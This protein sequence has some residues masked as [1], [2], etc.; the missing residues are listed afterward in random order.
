MTD[1]ISPSDLDLLAN[2]EAQF[3]AANNTLGFVRAHI[4]KTYKFQP[5]DTAD[6]RTGVI[7]R[8]APPED[9]HAATTETETDPEPAPEA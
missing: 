9:K 7:S 3:T 4:S 6:T 2:A 8:G 5:Y 1:V